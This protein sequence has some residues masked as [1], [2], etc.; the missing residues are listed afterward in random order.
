MAIWRPVG[1]VFE[2]HGVE[3]VVVPDPRLVVGCFLCE[4]VDACC[5]GKRPTQVI[6]RCHARNRGDNADVHFERFNDGHHLTRHLDEGKKSP[7]ATGREQ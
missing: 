3:Y 6:G 7:M 1:E 5:C 2:Y 4:F